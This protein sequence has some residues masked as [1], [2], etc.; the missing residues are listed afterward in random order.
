MQRLVDFAREREGLLVHDFAY[1]DVALDHEPPSIL[2]AEGADEVA[3]ELY[4]LTKSCSMAGWRVGFLVET[5]TPCRRWRGSSPTPT[6]A[7]SSRS[8]SRRSWR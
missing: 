2:Q 6:T 3:V 8:R 7:P 1:A 4:T 5:P